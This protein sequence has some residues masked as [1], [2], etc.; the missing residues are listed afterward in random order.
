MRG[1]CTPKPQGRLARSKASW[2]LLDCEKLGFCCCF[3]AASRCPHM[4][5][6]TIALWC[7]GAAAP[8]ICGAKDA[9]ISIAL[10]CKGCRHLH[11]FVVQLM[12]PPPLLVVHLM[13]AL[14]IA[15]WCN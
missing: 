10:W 14:T 7:K 8:L 11:C 13:P 9:A 5:P 2:M 1:A 4:L 15:L 3:H 6:L 12:P